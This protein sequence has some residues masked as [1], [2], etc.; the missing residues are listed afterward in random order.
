MTLVTAT[1]V[2]VLLAV[3]TFTVGGTLAS[4]QVGLAAGLA[5]FFGTKTIESLWA[6]IGA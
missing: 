3:C 2:G 4:P 6:A 5:A 1:S